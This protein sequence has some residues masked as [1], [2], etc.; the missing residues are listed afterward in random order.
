[1][2]LL[3]RVFY[4]DTLA[5]MH[6]GGAELRVA[7]L[8]TAVWARQG[9]LEGP[10]LKLEVEFLDLLVLFVERLECFHCLDEEVEVIDW[11]LEV[12]SALVE[13]TLDVVSLCQHLI[14]RKSF[15]LSILLGL[16]E[17]LII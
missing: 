8:L 14:V 5:A 6:R 12:P 16:L 11:P 10:R 1:M 15:D 13:L 4:D 3:V 7:G 9:L 2:I 17:I